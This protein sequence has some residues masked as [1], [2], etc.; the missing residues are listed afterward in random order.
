MALKK[1]PIFERNLLI[2]NSFKKF[3][4][5]KE[6]FRKARGQREIGTER[7]NFLCPF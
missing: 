3:S 1:D 6:E 4:L 5:I 7:L 2:D